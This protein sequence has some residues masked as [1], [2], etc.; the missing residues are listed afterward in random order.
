MSIVNLFEEELEKTIKKLGLHINDISSYE[1]RSER[2]LL[3]YTKDNRK[4]RI[5]DP[6]L[7]VLSKT[8]TNEEILA[9]FLTKDALEARLYALKNIFEGEMSWEKFKERY[10]TLSPTDLLKEIRKVEE[11]NKSHISNLKDYLISAISVMF[12]DPSKS[13][14]YPEGIESELAKRSTQ[15][16]VE[17]YARLSCEKIRYED[18]E[19]LY[20]IE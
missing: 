12:T 9:H 13:P 16:L 5:D 2:W 1:T 15:E 6:Y 14:Y 18:L 8:K 7:V 11:K 20:G 3:L 19:D 10:S 4:I 17:I